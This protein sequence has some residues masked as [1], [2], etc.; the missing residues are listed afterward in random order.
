MRGLGGSPGIDLFFLRR[1]FR[2]SPSLL[3]SIP[4]LLSYSSA[5]LFHFAC[6]PRNRRAN[7][8]VVPSIKKT[9]VGRDLRGHVRSKMEALEAVDRSRACES[10][11]ATT[12]G[13][14]CSLS[15]SLARLFLLP[16]LAGSAL[17][18]VLL[19]L[20]KL[21]LFTHQ[22]PPPTSAPPLSAK[23]T[24]TKT[25]LPRNTSAAPGSTEPRSSPNLTSPRQRRLR[26]R[27]GLSAPRR[28]CSLRRV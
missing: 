7:A 6:G 2:P 1:I 19:S 5:T 12:A 25:C 23:K 18:L 27:L 13:F 3:F 15:S 28:S 22:Q 10:E 26:P 24:E 4:C 20:S 8:L 17:W 14:R 16:T 11:R 9:L 21:I